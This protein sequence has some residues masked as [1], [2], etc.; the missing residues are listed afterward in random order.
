MELPEEGSEVASRFFRR[1]PYSSRPKP[2]LDTPVALALAF[3]WFPE[4][5]SLT[6]VASS[7]QKNL[8]LLEHDP[9]H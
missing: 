3:H 4:A 2:N 5:V 1:K 6:E 7:I 8:G 9:L